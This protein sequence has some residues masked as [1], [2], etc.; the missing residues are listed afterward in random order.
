MKSARI[1]LAAFAFLFMAATLTASTRDVQ[2]FAIVERVVFEPNE[3]SPERI[4][5]WGAFTTL[6]VNQDPVRSS[7]EPCALALRAIDSRAWLVCTVALQCRCVRQKS[8]YASTPFVV[9][10][11]DHERSDRLSAANTIFVPF[12]KTTR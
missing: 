9:L 3:K 12:S 8:I 1:V 10:S 4:K 5:L 2:I 11:P 7:L 6:Y